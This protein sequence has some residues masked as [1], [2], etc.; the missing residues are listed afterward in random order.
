MWIS[1]S[2]ASA[3]HSRVLGP[4]SG[5]ATERNCALSSKTRPV[6]QHSGRTTIEQLR[7]TAA[8]IASR[9]RSR[10]AST[11]AKEGA[12]CAAA[13]RGRPSLRDIDRLPGKPDEAYAVARMDDGIAPHPD[14]DD[15]A[16]E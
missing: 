1:C 14:D 8:M 11:F 15:V 5:S 12:Y 4:A 3:F 13:I 9:A 6:M 16:V 2:R 7:A 10:L